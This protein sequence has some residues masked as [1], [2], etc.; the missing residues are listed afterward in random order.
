MEIMKRLP[1]LHESVGRVSEGL[2]DRRVQASLALGA[3]VLEGATLLSGCTAPVSTTEQRTS[4]HAPIKPCSGKI[5]SPYHSSDKKITHRQVIDKV[6]AVRKQAETLYERALASPVDIKSGDSYHSTDTLPAYG[7]ALHVV[8][9]TTEGVYSDTTIKIVNGVPQIGPGDVACSIGE[10]ARAL[11]ITILGDV[12][13]QLN[14]NTENLP[15][16]RPGAQPESAALSVDGVAALALSET[17]LP[18][19]LPVA[20]LFTQ[21]A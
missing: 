2:K 13:R 19:P 7:S 8:R 1:G 15:T 18:P 17:G 11:R 16:T 20:D 6:R 4:A 12:I 5:D 3:A 21:V 14:E 10:R 9:N